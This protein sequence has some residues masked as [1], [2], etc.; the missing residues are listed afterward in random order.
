MAY[1]I[2]G[3][4]PKSEVQRIRFAIED[5]G[6]SDCVRLRGA[7][8][9]EAVLAA[10]QRSDCLL[11]PSLTEGISNAVLEAMACGLPVVTTDCGGMQEA[12]TDGVDGMIV[13]TRD[14]TGM[15][16]ALE[17][18]ASDLRLRR[19]LGEAARATVSKR[20]SLVRQA[21][22]FLRLYDSVLR[23]DQLSRKAA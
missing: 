14:V 18:L 19:R 11:L 5:L 4:G 15:A 21:D 2:A 20:F 13:R 8:P 23:P 3:D 9:P 12:V 6:L 1:E 7:V 10:L 17:R 22:E 16:A